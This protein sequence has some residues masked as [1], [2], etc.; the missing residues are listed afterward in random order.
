MSPPAATYQDALNALLCMTTWAPGT[1][2]VDLERSNLPSVSTRILHMW[3]PCRGPR[4]RR[5][6]VDAV[7]TLDER[8]S[9]EMTMPLPRPKHAWGSVTQTTVLWARVEGTEQVQRARAFR[10]APTLVLQEGSSSRRLLLWA[11]DRPLG[12]S[13][14]VQANK[15]LAYALHAVQKHSDSG[16]VA[17]PD[18]RD[19]LCGSAGRGRRRSVSGGSRRRSPA[20]RAC[21]RRGSS[22]AS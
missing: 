3:I 16:V 17:D 22:S 4:D 5:R 20:R 10:P 8:H 9:P 13:H 15:R 7:R 6:I 12:W 19:V 14:A 11:V 2:W 1:E 21:G 18:P